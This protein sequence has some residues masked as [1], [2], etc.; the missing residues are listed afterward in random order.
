MWNYVEK[1]NGFLSDRGNGIGAGETMSLDGGD[2]L[3][4]WKFIVF[5]LI[6]LIKRVCE[7][8]IIFEMGELILYFIE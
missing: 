2:F 5:C 1:M 6:I 4:A 8:V 3:G 7:R